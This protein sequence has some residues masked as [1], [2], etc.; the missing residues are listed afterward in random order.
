LPDYTFNTL[1]DK[2]FEVLVRELLQAELGVHLE[3]FKSGKDQ[4]ID[5]RYTGNAAGDGTTIIQA[6]HWSKSG[7]PPLL[8]EL[9]KKELP[10]V[11]KLAPDR[12]M[13]ATSVPLNPKNKGDIFSALAPYIKNTSDIYGLDDLNNLLVKYPDIEKSHYKLWVSSTAVLERILHNAVTGRSEFVREQI[14][15]KARLFV[16]T[17][18]FSKA[19]EILNERQVLLIKGVPGVGKTTLAEF[20]LY[21]LLDDDFELVAIDDDLRDAEEAF[22]P[23]KRQAFYFDDFLGSNYLELVNTRSSGSKIS[24]FMNRV[25]CDKQKRL[26]LTTRTTILNKALHQFHQI[27][28]PNLANSEYELDIDDYSR[29]DKAKILYNHLYFSDEEPEFFAPIFEN[30]G[31]LKVIDH[32]NYN[33]RIIEFIT[34]RNRLVD[35]SSEDYLGFVQSNLDSP[36]DI[37]EVAY[38]RQINDEARFLLQTLFSLGSSVSHHVLREAFEARVDYEVRN[39]GLQRSGNAFYSSVKLLLDGFIVHRRGH[40]SAGEYSFINPSLVDYFVDYFSRGAQEKWRVLDSAIY[41]EQVGEKFGLG[42]LRPVTLEEG[43][44]SRYL[45][46]ITSVESDWQSAKGATAELQLVSLL[47]ASFDWSEIGEDVDRLLDAVDLDGM[48]HL[49]Y[50]ETV[51][52]IELLASMPDANTCLVARWDGLILSLVRLADERDQFLGI[53][54]LFDKCEFSYEDWLEIGSHKLI[55]QAALDGFWDYELDNA[56]D[57]SGELKDAFNEE[58]F[59]DAKFA[60]ETELNEFND[61]F[62]MTQSPSFSRIGWIDLEST[63][64]DN[65]KR[66]EAENHKA[67]MWREEQSLTRP[68]ENAAID[69]LFSK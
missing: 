1:N 8:R 12:Y 16:P 45:C 33:P 42:T 50:Y 5:L 25:Q 10:K 54:E 21:R 18:S 14:L 37:W 19:L 26:I 7:F 11:Q 52:I 40:G 61:K 15:R 2:D 60:L 56:I 63:L 35:L 34:D 68:S 57:A 13:V 30:K 9:A 23:D 4:G 27:G 32:K 38:E 55:M 47:L 28:A 17:G 22:E 59:D 51:Y 29:M 39:G 48:S 67:D 66:A 20:I 53:R 36:N 69:D 31:Y 43:E 6:K 58:T 64:S 41:V 24:K 3:S 62:G 49:D 46:L 44:R 65:A